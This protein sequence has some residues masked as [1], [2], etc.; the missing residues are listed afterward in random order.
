MDRNRLDDR[1]LG[2]Y[3]H[4]A[5]GSRS[6]R[7]QGAGRQ[8]LRIVYGGIHD[9]DRHHHGHLHA[10]YPPGAHRGSF[11]DRHHFIIFSPS[12]RPVRRRTSPAFG[13][14]QPER[15]NDRHLDDH[16][17]LCGFRPAGLALA[18]TAGLFEH[19][20]KN[21]YDRGAGRRDLHRH[22]GIAHAGR[23]QIH[24][25]Y[26]P[27]LFRQPVLVP[28]HHHRLRRRIRIPFPH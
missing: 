17:R 26:G 14:L 4:P 3:D 11:I 23:H 15:G 24:R 10:V 18:R 28:V 9:T 20:F 6:G 25:R 13:N 8:P 22:A 19:L 5:R 12:F 27:G 7:R 1:H 21:R 16:L 2:N